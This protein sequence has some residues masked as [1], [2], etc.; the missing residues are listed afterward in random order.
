MSKEWPPTLPEWWARVSTSSVNLGCF[1]RQPLGSMRRP[2]FADTVK[3]TTGSGRVLMNEIAQGHDADQMSVVANHGHSADAHSS[4]PLEDFVARF[5]CPASLDF[6]RHGIRTFPASRC[7]PQSGRTNGDVAVGDDS[8]NAWAVTNGQGAHAVLGHQFSGAVEGGV[9][10][11]V[12]GREG[13]DFGDFAIEHAVP[14]VLGWSGW[15]SVRK[16]RAGPAYDCAMEP[17]FLDVPFAQKD[18]VKALGARFDWASKRWFVPPGFNPLAF[19]QWIPESGHSRGTPPTEDSGKSSGRS[20]SA[21]LAEV[22]QTVADRFGGTIWVRADVASFD[23]KRGHVYFDLVENNEQGQEIAR[24]RALIWNDDRETVIGPFESATGVRFVAGIKVLVRAS[25]SFHSRFGLSLQIREIDPDYTM[26]ELALRRRR[27][28]E[29]LV[30]EGIYSDNRQKRL[31]R[32]FFSVVVIAPEGAAGLGDFRQEADRLERLGLCF[33]TYQVAVF[34]GPRAS[35][36]LSTALHEAGRW[37]LSSGADAIALLRGGGASAD[38]HW[39]DDLEIARALCRS[40]VPVLIG[41]GHERD[42]TILDE[43]ARWVGGTPSKLIQFVEASIAGSAAQAQSA[44][45]TIVTAANQA[46]QQAQSVSDQWR[47]HLN[48]LARARCQLADQSLAHLRGR[49]GDEARD[50]IEHGRRQVDSGWDRI[51]SGAASAIKVARHAVD[52]MR[53]QL[54]PGAFRWV[55]G[56]RSM[57]EPAWLELTRHAWRQWSTA[58]TEVRRELDQ[59]IGLGPRRTLQRGFVIVRNAGRPIPSL[60]QLNHNF[61]PTTLSLEFRDGLID[62]VLPGE[63]DER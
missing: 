1:W 9:G 8:D 49:I 58:N 28:R 27:I 7:C 63:I 16:K 4:H 32:D 12:T 61:L 29:Q 23:P 37:A 45:E 62:V 57:T 46:L 51:E 34:Q 13:H 52:S 30:R 14:R 42:Q 50:V 36:S 38:L 43:L 5:V 39:L 25:V 18:A 56:A 26:G 20:L 6:T 21:L 15:E 19:A 22:A 54:A 41:V 11:D 53:T 2:G 33:F 47:A 17:V 24:A 55:A 35:E 48:E 40:P 3:G 31:P 44:Y 59:V 60:A 10:F